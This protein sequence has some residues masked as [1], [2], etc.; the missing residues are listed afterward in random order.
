MTFCG[1]HGRQVA[2]DDRRVRSR[3]PL[4]T[5]TSIG[6]ADVEVELA[7]PP[8]RGSSAGRGRWPRTSTSPAA[9]PAVAAG[10]P[11]ATRV[12]RH[13]AAGC[14]QSR[15]LPPGLDLE[16]RPRRG[17]PCRADDLVGDAHARSIGIAKPETDAAAALGEDRRVDADRPRPAA[18]ASGPPELP[19]LIAASVWIMS[20]YRPGWFPVGR[21]LR[22]VALTTP[23]VTVGSELPSRKAYGIAEGDDPLADHQVVLRADR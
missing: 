4:R 2:G 8:S 11:G 1:G 6:I 7:P 14:F 10:P 18:L 19:G 3:V 5:A 15:M 21:M 17:A 12:D 20:R 23:A 16:A 13:A 22:P 9:S